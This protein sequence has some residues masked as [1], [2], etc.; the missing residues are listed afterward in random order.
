MKS[1]PS[2]SIIANFYNSER[3]IP[4]LIKIVKTITPKPQLLLLF[5]TISTLPFY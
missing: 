4:K 1:S 3:F 5:F 2:I